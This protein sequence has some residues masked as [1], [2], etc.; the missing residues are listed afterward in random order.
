MAYG[1]APE[2]FES[3]YARFT[4]RV[5]FCGCHIWMGEVD[6]NGYGKTRSNGKRV[7]AHRESYKHFVGQI[8]DGNV[9]MHSC[10]TPSCVNPNHLSQGTHQDNSDDMVAKKRNAVG[11]RS[12]V[13]TINDA[14]A[15][16]IFNFSGKQSDIAKKFDVSQS[17]VSMIKRK[18]Y[19]KHIHEGMI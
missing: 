9:I 11:V 7:M 13:A 18:L 12:N 2:P 5:P 19:W 4:E 10:D 1:P 16:N 8:V 15:I 17:T 6:K 14:T 3:K